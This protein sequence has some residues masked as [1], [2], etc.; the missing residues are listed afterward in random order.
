LTAAPFGSFQGNYIADTF[1][2]SSSTGFLSAPATGDALSL[3]LGYLQQNASS[4]GLT[5]A[6]ISGAKVTSQYTDAGTGI[7]H[8]Y[9]QQMYNGL[10]V[11]DAVAAVNLMPDGSV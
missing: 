6:D 7:S 4:F 11:M 9:Y 5:S 10:P 8:I 1:K 3:G 2:S